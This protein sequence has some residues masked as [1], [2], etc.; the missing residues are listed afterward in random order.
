MKNPSILVQD[1][2]KLTSRCDQIR[3]SHILR[4]ANFLVDALVAIGHVD[5]VQVWEHS[6]QVLDTLLDTLCNFIFLI[7]HR[8]TN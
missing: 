2:L 3:F 6:L 5:G 8:P 1:I 4:E 7:E